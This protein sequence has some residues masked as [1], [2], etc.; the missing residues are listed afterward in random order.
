MEN[1]DLVCPICGEPTS[2]YMGNARKDR[3]CRKHAAMLKKGEIIL[4]DNGIFIDAKTSEILNAND[5]KTDNEKDNTSEPNCIICG[6]TTEGGW[7][8]LCSDCYYSCLE[9]TKEMNKNYTIHEYRN[10]YYNAKSNIYT[11]TGFENFIKPNCVK[12]VAIAKACSRYAQSEILLNIVKQDIKEIIQKK[13]GKDII[14]ETAEEKVIEFNVNKNRGA[15]RGV[16]GHFLD[17]DKEKEIDDLLF[18]LAIPHA[19]HYNVPEITERT[20]IC[21]WYIPV[22]PGKGIYVEYFG[23]DTSD[24]IR[25]REEK[26]ELYRKHGLKLIRIEKDETMDTQ[27][28]TTHIR[29]EW[30]KLKKEIFDAEN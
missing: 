14:Q 20:V 18:S 1:K 5:V 13:K 27:R 24:Y 4:N 12:L 22:L 29:Q 8:Y 23:M 11:L 26:I 30:T 15:I 10:Y 17:S 6:K 19:I 7:R 21:D 16:D 2:V 9:Y 3:L 28:L 25:N